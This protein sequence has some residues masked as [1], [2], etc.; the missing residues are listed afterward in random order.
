MSEVP[1]LELQ[2]IM[3]SCWH[4]DPNQR[5]TFR[6][7]CAILTQ[8]SERIKETEVNQPKFINN[9]FIKP[10]NIISYDYDGENIKNLGKVWIN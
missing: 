9:S 8:I 1:F 6:D 3:N 4:L 2:E 7:L 5:P 10:F